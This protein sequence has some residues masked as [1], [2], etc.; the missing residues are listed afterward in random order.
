[1]RSGSAAFQQFWRE[2][3]DAANRDVLC[4]AD[5]D[6]AFPA[7]GKPSDAAGFFRVGVDVTK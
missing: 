7:V 6:V 5:G 1:M 2:N 3:A 4:G